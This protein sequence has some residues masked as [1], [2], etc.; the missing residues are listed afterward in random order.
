M[1]ITLIIFEIILSILLLIII[2]RFGV[3]KNEIEVLFNK[4]TFLNE[5]LKTAEKVSTATLNQQS[6]DAVGIKWYNLKFPSS[7][8]DKSKFTCKTYQTATK[9]YS[10]F[11][12]PPIFIF[13]LWTILLL[14]IIWFAFL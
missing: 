11:I 5:E 4:I 10:N 12:R 7:I 1:L 13:A 2:K 8:I 14:L 6:F 9:D 3:N